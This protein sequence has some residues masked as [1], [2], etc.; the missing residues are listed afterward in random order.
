TDVQPGN[1]IDLGSVE[2]EST[3]YDPSSPPSVNLFSIVGRNMSDTS[4]SLSLEDAKQLF[5]DSWLLLGGDDAGVLDEYGNQMNPSVEGTGRLSLTHLGVNTLAKRMCRGDTMTLVEI[6]YA[7]SFGVEWSD[8]SHPPLVTWIERLQ[9]MVDAAWADPN[10]PDSYPVILMFNKGTSISPTPPTIT[11]DM[12]LN[13]LQANLLVNSFLIYT[14]DPDGNTFNYDPNQPV[15]LACNSDLPPS[16]FLLAGP[17]DPV[18]D[19]GAGGRKGTMR[20]FWKNYFF[21]WSNFPMGTVAAIS[22]AAMSA[23]IAVS[24]FGDPI[25][26]TIANA[27]NALVQGICADIA[28]QQMVSLNLMCFV[29][30]TPIV[31]KATVVEGEHGV[32]MV[33]VLFY[34]SVSDHDPW[35]DHESGKHYWYTLYRYENPPGTTNEK[36]VAVANFC[37]NCPEYFWDDWPY[38]MVDIGMEELLNKPISMID[39]YPPMNQAAYYDIVVTQCTQN[40]ELIGGDDNLGSTMDWFLG[41]I[42]GMSCQIGGGD[43]LGPGILLATLNP[44]YT[45]VQGLKKLTSDFSNSV[46][47]YVGDAPAV[48]V[49]SL[50]VD[51]DTGLVY[52]SD[53]ANKSLFKLEWEHDLLKETTLFAGTGFMDPGQIGLAIDL[54]GNLYSENHASDAMYGGR[55]FKFKKDTGGREFC[56]TVSYYSM[57]LGYARPV[58]V[59]QMAI[60][61]GGDL[62]VAEQYSNAI[63][64]VP[65]DEETWDP[66]RRV[67]QY[68]FNLWGTSGSVIDIE[69]D[70]DGNILVLAMV[71]S[72]RLG[73]TGGPIPCVLWGDTSG[74]MGDFL[75]FEVEFNDTYRDDRVGGLAVDDYGNIYI[76]STDKLYVYDGKILMYPLERYTSIRAC[77]P[78]V[79]MEGLV[80][81]GDIELSADGRALY[82]AQGDGT[83]KKE[84]FGLS[85]TVS[86]LSGT[87]PLYGAEVFATT[88]K[89]TTK[90]YKADA[91]GYFLIPGISRSDLSHEFVEI[92]IEYM[93]K[94]KTYLT[95]FGQISSGFF[96]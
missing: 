36:G 89:G 10:N 65:V 4:G 23:T 19:P 44:A 52:Y 32:P 70:P 38:S 8:G 91:D 82:I 67:G 92:T 76:S 53:I 64:R 63:V 25:V 79:I 3:V 56:G 15:M 86:D 78:V 83:I 96:G 29:P 35:N 41:A 42:P 87:I 43:I 59:S 47:V 85:G 75:V 84:F 2:T 81:P 80:N 71:P 73:R 72:D 13:I 33:K 14:F 62:F 49:D 30:S 61:P 11:H 54:Y 46:V 27:A 5:I 55:L 1:T 7:F 6:L 28:M 17:G 88:A 48:A 34:R 93:G 77:D 26:T 66:Y 95:R 9:E 57:Q 94:R 51:N 20:S 45:L 69:F 12:H 37:T 40:E 50:E 22:G 60:G 58:S 21:G 90:S 39:P 74:G 18:I 24:S 16:F 68:A 31:Q